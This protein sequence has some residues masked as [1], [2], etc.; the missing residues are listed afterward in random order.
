MTMTKHLRK[1]APSLILLCLLLNFALRQTSATIDGNFINNTNVLQ[2]IS[3]ST[4]IE[5]GYEANI[6]INPTTMGVYA[7]ENGYNLDL[8]INKEGIGRILIET[9]YQLDLIPWKTFPDFSDLRLP[10]VTL[11]KKIV[12]QGFVC[13]INATVLNNG[14]HYE[15][16]YATLN[17]NTTT[18]ERQKAT[19]TSKGTIAVTFPWNTTG[20][21]KGNYT[22]SAYANSILGKVNVG[23]NTSVGGWVIVA[24]VGD[25]NGPD[26]WPD[27]KVDIRDIGIIAVRFGCNKGDPCYAPEYDLNCDGKI[28]ILDIAIAA[29]EFGKVDP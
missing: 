16:F 10:S 3:E 25:V 20:F 17:A 2:M 6:F 18:I 23:N 28:D 11:A 22:I 15:T 27:G 9:D 19:L 4:H 5:N 26:G 24:M 21:A 29:R 14:L 7:E 13:R 12:G 8:T 1:I